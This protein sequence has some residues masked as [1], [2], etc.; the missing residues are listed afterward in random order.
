[1]KGDANSRQGL[2]ITSVKGLRVINPR[3]TNTSGNS[4]AAGIDIEPDANEEFLQDIVIENPY[5]AGNDGDGIVVV[6]TN[7][8]GATDINVDIKITNHYD[9][10][11]GR[12]FRVNALNT[13]T[14]SVKGSIKY[15]DGVSVEP[16]TAAVSIFNYDSTGPRVDIIRP[17]S[18]RPN[19]ASS[20]A[21][22]AGSSFTV[23]RDSGDTGAASIGNVRFVEPTS[24]DDRASPQMLNNF[25]FLDGESDSLLN[26]DVIDPIELSGAQTNIIDHYGSGVIVDRRELIK[27]DRGDVSFSVVESNWFSMIT[28][29]SQTTGTTIATLDVGF[30]PDSPEITFLVEA[31]QTFRIDPDATSTIAPYGTGAGTYLQSNTIGN[32]LTIKRLDSTTWLVTNIVGTWTAE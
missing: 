27:I 21:P 18:Y 13:S 5:T 15:I 17:V 28:N 1:V 2:S 12:S 23:W 8:V 4:P 29:A 26:V 20:A 10:Q 7:V 30:Q 32:R 25:Y 19:N 31:A 3:F 16:D 9:Y 6:L 14:N 24:I 11:S 22:T